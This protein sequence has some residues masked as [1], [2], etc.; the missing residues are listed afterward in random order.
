MLIRKNLSGTNTDRHKVNTQK[1][2]TKKAK[3]VKKRKNPVT[4]RINL[5]PGY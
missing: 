1:D 5:L 3:A 4:I 2:I